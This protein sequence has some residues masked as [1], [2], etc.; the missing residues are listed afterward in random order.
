[1]ADTIPATATEHERP[2]V[3]FILV[4]DLGWSDV[5]FN[6][7]KVYETP[8]VN[9]LA[10]Q[11]MVFTD[12]YSAG[13]VCSPTRASIMTGKYPARTGITTYLISPTRD[14]EHVT[15]FL[16]LEELTI[17]EAFKKHGYA[18]GY[19][20]K[21]HLG[22]ENPYWAANQGFDVAK[23]GIDLPWAWT[24]CYPDI[25]EAP[26]AKTW[27]KT[28]TRFFSPYHLTHLEDGPEGEYLTDRLTNETI[29]FIK[30]YRDGPF[31]AF[32]SFHTVHTPLQAKADKIEKYKKK[33]AAL[34]LDAAKEKDPREKA[35]QNNAAY[36]AMVEHMDENVGRLVKRLDEL[37]LSNS[38][39]VVWTSDN[40][41]KGSVTSNL[42]LRGMKH[43]LY[44]GG[45]RVPLI[46]RWPG[47][48]APE[49]RSSTP[50]I[51]NDF[52]PTLL[53]LAGC[54]LEP[55]QHTDGISFKDV[56]LGKSD[57]VDRE[58]IYWHY[59][60][61]RQEAAV[62][63]GRHKLLHRFK[64]DRVELYDLKADIGEQHDLSDEQP[65][66][67]QRL[68]SKLNA[69]QANVGAR[70]EGDGREERV[71][72]PR[73]S[74]QQVKKMPNVLFICVDD[75]NDWVGC[76]GNEQAQTP[77]VDR[78]AGRGLL[79]ANAHCVAP[80]CNPSRVAT[81]T[82][83][84]PETTGVY[85]N[86]HVM[87]RKVPSVVTLPQHFREHGYYVAGGGKVFHDVP[88][89]CDDPPSWDE[90]FWWNEHGPRG[91]PWGSAWRSPYSIPPDPEPDGRPARKIT[92]LTK[93]N[94]DWAAVDQP[95]SDWPDS[96]V[97][98]WASEFLAR[99]H[100]KPFF[101]AVGI[102]RP[103]VPWFNP[104][105]YIE[106]YPLEELI[107]PAVNADDLDDL[108]PWAKQR[109]LDRNSR[110]DQLVQFNEWKPA[111]QAYLASISF[112]DANVGRVL[113]ALEESSY[114]D[115]TVVVFWSDHGYHL[116]EKGH[117]HKR[118]LWERSTRVP[119]IISA[120]GVTT[121]GKECR[122]PVSLLDIYPTLI[123]V[124][125]LNER[126]ELEGND[127]SPLLKDPQTEWEHPAITTW[128]PSNHSVRTER[129]RYIR[130]GA[131]E[132]ELYDHEADPHEW[133][134]LAAQ[135]E[136]AATKRELA[137][138]LPAPEVAVGSLAS[139]AKTGELPRNMKRI[140]RPN[141]LLIVSEDNGPELGCYGTPDVRTPN[142]DRL[143]AEGCRFNNAYVT[144]AV[145]SASRASFLTGLYP[146]QNGQ[147]G[148]AT[149]RY[150]MFQ[151]WDNIP[152]ILKEHGYRTGMVGKLHVNPESA[153]PLD[154]R[155][156][157][158]SGF[159]DR[160]MDRYADAATQFIQASDQ[161]FFLA[162]NFPDAHFPLL[163][164]QHGLPA[165]PL[166]GEQV[167]PLPFIG[168][169]TPRLRQGTA[170]YYNCLMRLDAGVGMLLEE[171][172]VAGKA[173]QTL[174]LYIGDHGAQFS[175]GKA[176][177]YE[178][179]L[180]IPLIVRW[181]G[182]VKP[183]TVCNELVSTI[184]ILPTAIQAAGLPARASLPGRSLLPL[185][186]DR[187]V[188]WREYLFAERTAY[189]AA[190]FFPQRTVRDERYKLI[191]NL[192]PERANPVAQTYLT[193]QAGFFLYGTNR[194]EID[195]APKPIQEAYATWRNPPPV[196]LYDLQND[197]WEFHNL[198]DKPEPAE[199]RQRLLDELRRFRH[200][201]N[202]PLLDPA[203]LEKL[204]AEHDHV[205]TNEK[206]GRYGK[207]QSWKYL[208]YL[209]DGRDSNE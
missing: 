122:R 161:P 151:N 192:T 54:P 47:K 86:N 179:G 44:E 182:Q 27:P 51:S 163:R 184:D 167:K 103:H 200:E 67:A 38:T 21:W 109:A 2:N 84:R 118:T 141:V 3:V 127:L 120:P 70:F 95:A 65:E 142:L 58:A 82:G 139:Q 105:K 66:L 195:A 111:V 17:A 97:A 201:H 42:P 209:R 128:Q 136:L 14:A 48:I 129:W 164:Q 26:T 23:G 166:S 13:P 99:K 188:R 116:G 52:Y 89:H 107:L 79:F 208:E 125:G 75:W 76:L 158:G 40:G 94:F 124:C 147:I 32:L 121:P 155:A 154:Y 140:D 113:D 69:W 74:G 56:L 133:N 85:E 153:F 7:S 34:G 57:S 108:G 19:F 194:Q 193:M 152:S 176:T 198:S 186:A 68:V 144:H 96:K 20:G 148:L 172:D 170:D 134:N 31:F 30:Q 104:R 11:G 197:P 73:R 9:R 61:G 62:R 110:H 117:W 203:K 149:H 29:Q 191:L 189:H 123:S 50:L 206:G 162:V 185:A 59:P 171:L 4:D 119:L 137:K 43:N 181:P 156:I 45:I 131:G 41:G 126:R 91:G 187:D 78:L 18:T 22:Y 92:P 145:C 180:R 183:G 5:G 8:H 150:S 174:V 106:R 87:R 25:E 15:S 138:H 146:F 49:S 207:G 115:N 39:I 199:V 135:A 6:G 165:E 168:V 159:N 33:I 55:K 46:V 205:A 173:H 10:Q 36:A 80:V 24:L 53:E 101:L 143:A 132:E 98:A 190:S 100:E 160:P 60:H 130:Y 90:Y 178:G 102:F 71:S 28:H 64:D 112:A 77:N 72:R 202:D 35:L 157:P 114:S 63:E 1:M 204:A 177:C 93:R 37:N 83:L 169:D 12:F 16:P 88:P 175:R 81:L 196:E